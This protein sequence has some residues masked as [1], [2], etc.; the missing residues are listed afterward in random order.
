MFLSLET[1][2]KQ[3]LAT[4]F[5]FPGHEF[6]I[7]RSQQF[8]AHAGALGLNRHCRN[9]RRKLAWAQ[10]PPRT[11]HQNPELLSSYL[12]DD[13]VYAHSVV[14]ILTGRCMQKFLWCDHLQISQNLPVA[15]FEVKVSRAELRDKGRHHSRLGSCWHPEL[16]LPTTSWGRGKATA[17]DEHTGLS[18][19]QRWRPDSKELH[20]RATF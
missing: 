4:H 9:Q 14:L 20:S 13:G 6:L 19:A 2:N 10:R 11:R 7:T 12:H 17:E 8:G 15:P 16:E 1:F 3:I 18:P 5:S